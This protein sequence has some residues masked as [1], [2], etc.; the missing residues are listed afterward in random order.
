MCSHDPFNLDRFVTTQREAFDPAM[1][2][3]RDGRKRGH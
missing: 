3:L 1:A 2:E